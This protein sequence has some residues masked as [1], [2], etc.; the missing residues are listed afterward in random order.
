MAPARSSLPLL[1]LRIDSDG[2]AAGVG[3]AAIH[4]GSRKAPSGVAVRCDRD[5]PALSAK[6]SDVG[7][8]SI[9]RLLKRLAAKAHSLGQL[10]RGDCTDKIFPRARCR[11]RRG[12]IVGIG[13]RA[14]Q[15]RIAHSP[16]A[17]CGKPAGRRRRGNIA[18]ESTATAPT[19]PYFTSSSN[20]SSASSSSSCRRRSGISNQLLSTCSSRAG[21]RN[22]RRRARRERRAGHFRAARRARLIG[23]RVVRR[24][25]TAPAARVA[26]VH[27]GGVELDAAARSQHAAATGV[28]TAIFLEHANRRLD[29]V[30]RALAPLEDSSARHE[31]GFQPGPRAS[32]LFRIEERTAH[33][34]RTAV[35]HQPPTCF[36]HARGHSGRSSLTPV[37][38]IRGSILL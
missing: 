15:R 17:L 24:P 12:P 8:H 13:A 11:N 37:D 26:P 2:P 5:Q 9:E 25:E 20:P 31:R 19:V 7:E 34:A 23:A 27:D 30:D 35:N 10:V 6:S 22:R 4:R 29:R 18:F 36:R 32:V 16:P 21:A 38:A 1:L 33:R 3:H 28:E 14:D